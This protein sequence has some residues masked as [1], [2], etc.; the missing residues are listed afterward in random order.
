MGSRRYLVALFLAFLIIPAPSSWGRRG[1][2]Y[3][4]GVRLS[5]GQGS[6]LVLDFRVQKALDDRILDTLDSGLP[7]RFTYWIRIESPREFARDEVLVD[8]KF[9]RILEKDNLKNRFRVILDGLGE[10]REM[11]DLA[12]AVKVMSRIEGVNLLPRERLLGSRPL[13]LKITARLQQFALPFRLHYL[14]AFVS[15]WDV[16]TDWYSLELPGDIK[17]LQ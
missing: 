2:A 13:F 15:F 16:E 10:A 11:T 4:D 9:V 5:R 17:A 3:I 12:E 8:L 1:Q 14:F 7:V 6:D